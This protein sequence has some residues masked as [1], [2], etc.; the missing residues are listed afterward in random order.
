MTIEDFVRIVVY[1]M[2]PLNL[3]IVAILLIFPVWGV[4]P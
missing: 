4:P 1:G 2:L 3:G